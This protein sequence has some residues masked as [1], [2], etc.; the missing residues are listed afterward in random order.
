MKNFFIGAIV[1]LIVCG[2]FI[3]HLLGQIKSFE[4]KEIVYLDLACAD[5]IAFRTAIAN[6]RDRIS[7]LEMSDITLEMLQAALLSACDAKLPR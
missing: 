7:V 5:K 6:N 2:L 3:G 4:D 1:S